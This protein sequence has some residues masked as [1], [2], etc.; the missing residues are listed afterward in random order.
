MGV[1]D[2]GAVEAAK[3]VLLFEVDSNSLHP[4]VTRN[5]VRNSVVAQ[6]RSYI[7]PG[8]CHLLFPPVVLP[9][10]LRNDVCVSSRLMQVSHRSLRSQTNR[11]RAALANNPHEP[12]A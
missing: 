11:R 6:P 4:R 3:I 9:D 7:V 8:Y 1:Q 5:R 2:V 12:G 10:P